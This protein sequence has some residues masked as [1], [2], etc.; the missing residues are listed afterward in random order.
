MDD[1]GD[2]YGEKILNRYQN[3]VDFLDDDKES[4]K[5]LEVD[6]ICMLLN[7]SDVIGSDEWS[8]KLLDDLNHLA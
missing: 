1:N 3:Y 8:K 5:E 2:K 7:V 4:L 6:I